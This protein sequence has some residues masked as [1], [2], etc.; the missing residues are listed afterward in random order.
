M[1][2]LIIAII[3]EACVLALFF[4]AKKRNRKLTIP[5]QFAA[6]LLG[7]VALVLGIFFLKTKL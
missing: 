1:A 5:Q 7:P 6:V 4:V 2:A 3:W